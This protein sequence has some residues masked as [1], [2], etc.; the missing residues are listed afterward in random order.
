MVGVVGGQATDELQRVGVGGGVTAGLG[1][2]Q[3][4][5]GDGAALPDDAHQGALVFALDGEDDVGDH[6]A[7]QQLA[8]AGGGGRRVKDR[9]QVSA[10][11]PAPG[12]LLLGQR[13]GAAGAD[14]GES[15]LGVAD[16]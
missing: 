16:V 12:D 4:V 9:A 13:L 11:V 3:L 1:Q 6:R 14:R 2:C 5:F 15:P 10:G 8:V 7:Q